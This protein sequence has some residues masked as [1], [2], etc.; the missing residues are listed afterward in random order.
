MSM[1]KDLKHLKIQEVGLPGNR[2]NFI[3][4]GLCPYYRMLCSKCRRLHNLGKIGYFYIS[5]GTIKV[6]VCENRNPI[7]ITHTQDFLKYF[8]EV[9]LLP[10]S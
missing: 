4:T 2:S 10:T 8:P 7:S 3:N 5:S 1:K 9:D 6:K